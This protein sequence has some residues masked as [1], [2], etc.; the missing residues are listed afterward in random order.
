MVGAA[1][2]RCTRAV[3][4][5]QAQPQLGGALEQTPSQAPP[6]PPP[7]SP[8]LAARQAELLELLAAC[9][10]GAPPL[11][12]VFSAHWCGPCQ[13]LAKQLVASAAQLRQPGGAGPPQGFT[14]VKVEAP[15]APALASRLGVHAL[16]CTFVAGPA[17]AGAPAL[18]F[19]G[20]L[21]HS[22]IADAVAVK[23]R[24]L[25]SDLA[26]AVQL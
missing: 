3:A 21:R 7:P 20:L 6:K 4:G 9:D 15:D 17:G 16:P 24:I 22:V 18:R 8:R 19:E 13:L 12:V 25:G 10:A 2:R 14:L 11:V 26:R 23:A 1:A 5:T